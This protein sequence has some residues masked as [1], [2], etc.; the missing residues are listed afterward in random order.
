MSQG[1]PHEAMRLL[2]I[3]PAS[4]AAAMRIIPQ[5]LT[6]DEG[7]IVE[8]ATPLQDAELLAGIIHDGDDLLAA[9]CSDQA[10][11]ESDAMLQQIIDQSFDLSALFTAEDV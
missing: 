10:A 1:I 2:L 5:N 6:P 3:A 8:N 4:E 9:L 7:G 11:R